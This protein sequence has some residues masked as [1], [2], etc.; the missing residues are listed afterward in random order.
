MA[1]MPR[2]SW[3]RTH[4]KFLWCNGPNR[5]SRRRFSDLHFGGTHAWN[6]LNWTDSGQT[7]EDTAEVT[8]FHCPANSIATPCR[9]FI[10]ILS[11][12]D[13]YPFELSKQIISGSHHQPFHLD[14]IWFVCDCQMMMISLIG[15]ESK[16]RRRMICSPCGFNG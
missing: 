14:R 6:K 8:R 4:N 3:K 1:T 9:Q 13:V 11:L 10:A 2:I 12:D 15:A 7:D 5:L 16:Q